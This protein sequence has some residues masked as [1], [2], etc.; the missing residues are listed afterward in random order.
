MAGL[1]FTGA[2]HDLGLG[3]L[4]DHLPW[5]L[6][7]AVALGGGAGWLLW[8]GRM[9]WFPPVKGVRINPSGQVGARGQVVSATVSDEPGSGRA[10]WRTAEGVLIVVRCHTAG[11]EIGFGEQV[12]LEDYDDDSRS[13]RVVAR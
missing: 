13:Y 12:Q 10:Q 9:R 1:T 7:G 3:S 4:A 11:N 5:I 6:P 8:R 2:V